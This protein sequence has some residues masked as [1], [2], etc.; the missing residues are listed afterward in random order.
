MFKGLF[1]KKNDIVTKDKIAEILKTDPAKLEEFE[2][3]YAEFSLFK[4][5]IEPTNLFDVNS[6]QAAAMQHHYLG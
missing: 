2:K 4:E 6:R 1:S 5:T 3:A